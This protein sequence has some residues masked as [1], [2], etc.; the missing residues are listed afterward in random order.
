MQYDDYI[1]LSE[2]QH[3]AF[4]RRQWALIFIENIWSENY[5]TMSGHL[6][7]KTVHTRETSEKRSSLIKSYGLSVISHDYG[8]RGVC[9]L[10]EFQQTDNSEGAILHGYDDLYKITPVEYKHGKEKNED[11][12]QAAA[13]AICLEEMFS[14]PVTTMI[15]YY[16]KTKE[17]VERE[18]SPQIKTQI[19]S[20][21]AEMHQYKTRHYIPHVRKKT[22]CKNCSLRDR[23]LPVI[24]TKSAVSYLMDRVNHYANS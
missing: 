23:C 1:L 3:F 11:F 10:V 19:K 13:Q 4:C 5:L 20:Y 6:E 9:D 14:C 7:H 24:Q 22:C 17:R 8:M 2:F 12:Y 18:I 16:K 21:A 15:V